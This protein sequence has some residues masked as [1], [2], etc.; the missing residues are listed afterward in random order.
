M[1]Y[2]INHILIIYQEASTPD[3][4]VPTRLEVAA[5]S[6]PKQLT[7]TAL[8]RKEKEK[9]GQPYKPS[10]KS[11][12]QSQN[13]NWRSPT[14]WP[15]IDRVV[16]EQVGKPNLS[17]IIRTL[18]S[19]DKWFEHLTHQR[20]SEWRDKTQKDKLVWSEETLKEVQKGFFPGGNQTRYNILV[21]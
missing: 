9:T 1:L 12:K 2:D 21:S 4:S 3:L 19:R 14:F 17:E 18:Q 5:A 11:S 7:V 15:M 20:L 16:K 13:I 10:K 6:C 8:K